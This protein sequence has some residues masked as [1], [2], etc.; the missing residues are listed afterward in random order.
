MRE[1]MEVHGEPFLLRPWAARDVAAL[2]EAHADPL[3]RWQAPQP[4]DTADEALRWIRR[5]AGQ[6]EEDAAYSFAVVERADP[7][8]VLGDI[9][10]S[11]VDRRHSTGWVSYWTTKSARGRGVATAACRT[12]CRW[13]F[14]ELGLF[15]LEL[16]HR[17]D[18]IASCRVATAA[19]FAV[20][21]CERQRLL[22]SG[23]RYDVE[24]HARLA[25][26]EEP[27]PASTEGR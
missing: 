16:G 15:R 21:G 26:D 12:V 17:V 24:R 4:V 2:L 23:V 27:G 8:V 9:T 22:Y 25:T 10:V 19:G 6:W 14:D 5:R 20:E 11:A 13:A 7:G 18:N 3:M 1:E